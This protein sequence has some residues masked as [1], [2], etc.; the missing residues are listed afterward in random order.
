MDT[1]RIRRP[2]GITRVSDHMDDIKHMISTLH[3]KEYAYVA[4]DGSV[5]FDTGRYREQVADHPVPNR[6]SLSLDDLV[7]N[8]EEVPHKKHVADF[9]LWKA[10]GESAI[11]ELGA[12]WE[13]ELKGQVIKGRPGWHIEC[14]AM[15]SKM[16]GK[17]LD[18]HAGGIDLLFPHH[19]NEVAQSQV[20]VSPAQTT[21]R[22]LPVRCMVLR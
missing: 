8:S 15:C 13:L 20:Q 11:A 2:H 17:S 6:S 7:E 1:L 12:E 3:E 5:Y 21:R 10:S 14:S 16:F 4:S 18:V 19:C 22:F 9:A